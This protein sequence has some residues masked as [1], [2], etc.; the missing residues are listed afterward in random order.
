MVSG[1]VVILYFGQIS[2]SLMTVVL[3]VFVFQEIMTIG[4]GPNPPNKLPPSYWVQWFF[5]V[6]CLLFVYV[7]AARDQLLARWPGFVHKYYFITFSM[8]FGAL[9]L[10]ILRLRRP[11]KSQVRHF[12]RTL[13]ALVLVVLQVGA[14]I[15]NLFQGLIWFLLPVSSVIVNDITAYV[16]GRLFGRT[17]LTKVS[18]N[19]TW[20]G[21]IG[22]FFCT[23]IWAYFFVSYTSTSEWII[24]P[25]T[26]FSFDTPA[27]NL[28]TAHGNLFSPRQFTWFGLSF[29]ATPMHAHAI[30][31]AVFVSLLAPFGGF[32]ASAVKRAFRIKD[33][34]SS[35]PG[36]GGV[37]DR[38]DCQFLAG[39]FTFVWLTSFVMHRKPAVEFIF[40]RISLLS[41]TE[42]SELI[43]GLVANQTI[44]SHLKQAVGM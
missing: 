22:A 35:I 17:K 20:E 40:H 36:H 21:F 28:H 33:F 16:F 31:I 6:P 42:F 39:T 12:A 5:F 34:G 3:D 4:Y 26:D 1:F 10:F 14:M 37:T 44:L 38:M 25:K 7:R 15:Y 41:A 13:V 23:L 11:Y 30:A 18:P 8:L 24:C 27:C 9:V 29:D 32:L 19:K 43:D 2:L